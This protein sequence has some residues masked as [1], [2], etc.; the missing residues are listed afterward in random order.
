[1]TVVVIGAIST[2]DQKYGIRAIHDKNTVSAMIGL[3]G[4]SV[5]VC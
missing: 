2:T 4:A 1:M 3:V 5:F